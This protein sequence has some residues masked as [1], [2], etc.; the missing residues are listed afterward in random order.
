MTP[1]QLYETG[2]KCILALYGSSSNTLS[3]CRY[4]KFVSTS[5]RKAV[6]FTQLPPTEDT[7][8]E[9]LKRVYLQ[10]QTWHNR[11]LDP[12]EW[13]WQGQ[14]KLSPIAM[15]QCAAPDNL[16]KMIFCGCKKGCGKACGCRKAGLKC[17]AA[18]KSC[19]GKQCTNIEIIDDSDG[20]DNNDDNSIDLPV[21]LDDANDCR[22]SEPMFS[23]SE[24]E[25]SSD[26]DS[27]GD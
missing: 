7:A 12:R 4:D 20:M 10:L 22:P 26:N 15:N 24:N 16:L 13:G 6:D 1:T 9:H 21:C 3:Q 14:D 17:S 5:V 2:H 25:C 27:D 18:C 11:K 8:N 23:D 19:K